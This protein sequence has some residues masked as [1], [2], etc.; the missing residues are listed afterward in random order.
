MKNELKTIEAKLIKDKRLLKVCG[1]HIEENQK[2][3]EAVETLKNY[4]ENCKNW[5]KNVN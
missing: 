2:A 1:N 3:L 5:G 4:F